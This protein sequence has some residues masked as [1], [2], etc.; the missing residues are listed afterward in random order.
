MF[1]FWSPFLQLSTIA[2]QSA[3]GAELLSQAF[4]SAPTEPS[5]A[6]SQKEP[7]SVVI[8]DA[9]TMAENVSPSIL[10]MMMLKH[11]SKIPDFIQFLSFIWLLTMLETSQGNTYARTGV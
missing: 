10:P 3:L 4:D 6:D 1:N 5:S 9:S 2:S 11:F 7:I 8:I